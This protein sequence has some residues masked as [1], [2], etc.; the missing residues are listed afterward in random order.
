MSRLLDIARLRLRSLFRRSHVERELAKELSF[1]LARQM[2]ENIARGMSPTEAR[3]AAQRAL[4]GVAQ[5]QEECRDMR[6][7]NHIET[8]AADLR[9]AIRSLRRTPSFTAIVVLTLALSI[10]ANS[11]IFSVIQGV[12]LRPLPYPHPDRLV[13]I[14]FQSDTQPKFPLN[15]NDFLDLR[16]RNRSFES[17]AAMTRHDVQLSGSGE[18]VMLS[19]FLV[20]AGY[21]H[22][23]G[24]SPARGREFSAEDELH[25]RGRSVIL[26]DR[27]WRTRFSADPAILGRTLTLD[28]VPFTIVGIMS[29]GA[30]HPG[31]N[32]HAVADGETVDVWCPF[33]FGEDTKDRGSHYLDVFGRLKPGV[34]Y[35]QATADLTAVL[36]QMKIELGENGWR[37]YS[38][39]LFQETVGRTRNM[40]LLL[41]GSVG[42]LLLIACVNAANLL[43]ARSSVRVREMAVRSA[44]GAA[45]SRIVR[46]LLTESLVIALAGAALGTLLAVGGVRAL[47]A[48]LLA[49]FPRATEIRLDSGVFLF[50][51][52]VAV[53]TGLLFGLAPALTASRADL[54]NS[55]RESGRGTTAGGRQSRLRSLLVVG[56][57]SLACVLLIGAGLLLH[58][59]VNLL[60]ADPGFR[61]QQVLTASVIL[62]YEQYREPAPRVLFF[63]H[64]IAALQNAPGVTAAGIGSDLPWT[65]YDGNADGYRIEGRPPDYQ[66]MARYHIAS[67]DYFRALGTPLL[68]GRFLTDRDT[69]DSPYVIVI[70]EAMANRYWPGEDAVGKRISFESQPKEKD[71]TRIVG[72]VQDV[73][74]Q[75]DSS[76][77]RPAFW[78][79]HTQQ[80]D[81]GMYV[82]VRFTSAPS[83][84]AAQLRQAVHQLNPDLAVADLRFMDQ[85]ADAAFS[86]QRFALFLVALFAALALALAT[87]GMYGVIS[88]SVNRRMSEFGLRMALGASP[89][90]LTRLIV[91]HG[92]ALAAVGTALGLAAAVAVGRLLTSL[93]YGVPAA[94]PITLAAVALLALTTAAIACYLPARRATGADPLRSLRAE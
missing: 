48:C 74:D 44:L 15:P 76:W 52:L 39:P 8:L 6:R 63:Q 13:R 71:W 50:T 5:I 51:L 7:T 79:P 35:Q 64:L 3:D 14:Y 78:L 34:S 10:G 73:K 92:L 56:E 75:P 93:L 60:R 55:L 57:T 90:D 62:P 29:A 81:R 49:G 19:G 43:L 69:A 33:D 91:G 36:S 68:R 59:F 94:D 40:L 18:P 67:P 37:I 89:W 24:L 31:N 16:K 42:L 47:V 22:M 66:T 83:E 84:A 46:Q 70:N 25:G 30:H 87:F 88:Y 4:G 12:L 11:A 1:H 26:S 53:L 23:L 17:M 28:Q 54:Q 86:G 32:F 77:V 45:R 85:I 21:F 27:L 65:G 20:S 38:L 2:E 82:A 58:S 72:V 80:S 41:L 9:Y 61:P